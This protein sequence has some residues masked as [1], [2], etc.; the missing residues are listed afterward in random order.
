MI[1]ETMLRLLVK[2]ES[3]RI[4]VDRQGEEFGINIQL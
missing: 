3:I 4:D 2:F 1:K